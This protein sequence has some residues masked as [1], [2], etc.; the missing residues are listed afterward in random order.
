MAA[1]AELPA[2]AAPVSFDPNRPDFSPYGLSCVW[3]KPSPMRRPDHH[4]E[5][6]LN[7]IVSGSVTYLIAGRKVRIEAGRLSSFWAAIPHQ[8]VQWETRKPYY[9]A[10][11]P[12][13]WFLGCGFPEH[14]AHP[15]LAGQRADQL[16]ASLQP[17]G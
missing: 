15:I 1:I 3:W 13:A 6:E 5:I 10:T 14:F 11:L 4:N 7:L 12:L 17:A 9:V 2:P 8:I 16:R